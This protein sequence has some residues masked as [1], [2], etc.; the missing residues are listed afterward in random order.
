LG[1]TDKKVGIFLVIPKKWGYLNSHKN[2]KG[3]KVPPE[4]YTGHCIH[5]YK[6]IASTENIKYFVDTDL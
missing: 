1:G 3:W 5:S 4:K 6:T 2:I